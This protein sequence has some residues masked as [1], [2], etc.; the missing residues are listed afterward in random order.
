MKVRFYSFS[1][2]NKSTKIP[3]NTDSYI[4][5]DLELKD[6]TSVLAPVFLMQ[7]LDPLQYNY[8]YVPN[9][10]RYYFINDIRNIT[11]MWEVSM[12][13][14]ILG[15]FKT[16]IGS[17]SAMIMYATG[18]ANNIVDSRIP[19]KSDVIRD[20]EVTQFNDLTFTTTGGPI[21][22]GITGKG[23]FG[24]YLMKSPTQITEMV[25]G[26]DNVVSSF[27]DII[28]WAKQ[29]EYGGTASE[30]L[31]SA[32]T[33]PFYTLNLASDVS[34]GVAEDLVLGNYPC[35]DSGGNN[36]Q[37]YHI[38]KPI[39]T[40]SVDIDIPWISNDWKRVSAYTT[41]ELFV[42][43][44]GMLNIPATDIMDDTKLTVDLAINVTS[45]DMSVEVKGKQTGKIV[46]NGS[47][48]CA[49]P[50]AY[51]STGIDTTKQ[52]QA[53]ATGIGSIVTLAAA[54]MSGGASLGVQLAT[55][56]AMAAATGMMI[57]SL[58]GTGTGSA[59][60]GGGASSGLDK[61]IYLFVTQKDLTDT[62]ANFNPLMGKPV[63]A[64]HTVGTYSGYVQ[65]DG[66]QFQSNKAYGAEKDTINQMLDLGIYYE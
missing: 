62:Q 26:V 64:V 49:I 50:T 19:V 34:N 12:T 46:A 41:V 60:L 5:K 20:V 17:T 39:I 48:N 38:T 54:T 3:A 61:D 59:G 35:K 31:K 56:G 51:G 18:G 13:E 15:S 43:L 16:E 8:A 32:I 65:T 53:Y 55:G 66:F 57:Q 63:M 6:A 33:L 45:G 22:I 4:E 44:I 58:G 10:D 25:D 40:R 37:G 2:R 36:I 47:G 42:P 23:S 7:T 30:C 29:H 11:N 1:K 52:S 14:D 24:A 27:S 28:D 21:V 9:W